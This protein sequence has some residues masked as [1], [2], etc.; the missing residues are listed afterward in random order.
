[1]KVKVQ[2]L[3]TQNSINTLS[4]QLSS[5][6]SSTDKRSSSHRK[7]YLSSWDNDPASFYSSYV[8][9]SLG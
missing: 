6:N 8:Y 2:V 1:M 4:N 9:D 5:K 7:R 3:K